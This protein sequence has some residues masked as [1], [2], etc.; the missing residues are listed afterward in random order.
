M[1]EPHLNEKADNVFQKNWKMS[2]LFFLFF[3]IIVIDII[4]HL[5]LEATQMY[6]ILAIEVLYYY[7]QLWILLWSMANSVL[8]LVH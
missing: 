1:C 4:Y 6:L 3:I 8:V 5:W 7:L 2:T